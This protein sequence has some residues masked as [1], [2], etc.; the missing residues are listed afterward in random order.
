MSKHKNFKMTRKDRVPTPLALLGDI[1]IGDVFERE[2]ALHMRVNIRSS[3]Q[4]PTEVEVC[5]LNT[6]SVWYTSMYER[7]KPAED[8]VM[9]YTPAVTGS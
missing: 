1:E 7:V 4:K 5:N 3:P 9:S 6:G 2:G 8:C